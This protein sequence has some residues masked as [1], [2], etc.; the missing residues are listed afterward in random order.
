MTPS[1]LLRSQQRV[2][3]IHE[4][5]ETHDASNQVFHISLTLEPVADSG[6]PPQG[7]EKEN[8][9]Q[10]IRRVN[11]LKLFLSFRSAS[12]KATRHAEACATSLGDH[13]LV[14]CRDEC[15]G[16]TIFPGPPPSLFYGQHHDGLRGQAPRTASASSLHSRMRTFS[17]SVSSAFSESNL[18][19]KKR[20]S[21]GG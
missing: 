2:N 19:S 8:G 1:E 7:Y 10:D 16:K 14:A 20:G 3:Q 17:T 9:N 13:H 5:A 6:E 12:L 15:V 11:H 18:F 4:Q 21:T